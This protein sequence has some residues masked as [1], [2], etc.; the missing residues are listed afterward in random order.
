ML[1]T[2]QLDSY[3]YFKLVPTTSTS[4]FC[5]YWQFRCNNGQCISRSSLCNGWEDCSD[6]SDEWNWNCGTYIM[7]INTH[8]LYGQDF[9]GNQETGELRGKSIRI[10]G[11]MTTPMYIL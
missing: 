4:N 3:L 2:L 9:P 5:Y 8:Y 7:T 10:R 6:G 1:E 11:E